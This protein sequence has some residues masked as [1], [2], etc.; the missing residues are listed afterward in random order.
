ML[1]AAGLFVSAC[2]GSSPS[3]ADASALEV[4]R[5]DWEP[6]QPG[7]EALG[8]G[9]LGYEQPPGAGVTIDGGEVAIPR[10]YRASLDAEG[11][12]VL[13]APGRPDLVEGD[14]V[15]GGGGARGSLFEVQSFLEV[16]ELD[17]EACDELDR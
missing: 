1:L 10:V 2:G 6:G 3:S 17:E 4:A 8:Q 12:L 15:K 5:S 7:Q 9:R 11:R 16:L 14:C 13:S